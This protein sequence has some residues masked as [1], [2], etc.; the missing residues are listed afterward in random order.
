MKVFSLAV[1]LAFG[2]FSSLAQEKP[3]A[4][5]S[6]MCPAHYQQKPSSQ[7]QHH[8]GVEQRGDEVMGFSHEKTTHHFR[9]YADGGAIE[10]EAND[11]Q[12]TASRDEIRSHLEHIV[13]MFAAG[14]FS[15]PML[16]HA[17]NPPGTEEM[18]KLRE[19]IQYEVENT[20][21][22]ARIR[23]TT[24]DPQ[25]LSAVHVFLRFQ[26]SDHQT[27]DSLDVTKRP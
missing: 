21:R 11:A 8:E 9:L 15:A 27:G 5:A 17:Q 12:D 14:N 19:S 4:Q 3:A 23:I 26:I 10:V 20:G 22:G 25:A 2:V 24:K 16:I 18:R 1:I 13:A 6:P 7:D